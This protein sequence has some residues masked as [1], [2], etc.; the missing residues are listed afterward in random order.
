MKCAARQLGHR[1]SAAAAIETPPA[2]VRQGERP[3]CLRVSTENAAP[4]G[5]RS[6][7]QSASLGNPA[8]LSAPDSHPE[9]RDYRLGRH[10]RY[11]GLPEGQRKNESMKAPMTLREKAQ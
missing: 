8:H 5:A 7:G 9:G 10:R 2:L 1:H 6:A 3:E 11:S 4:S